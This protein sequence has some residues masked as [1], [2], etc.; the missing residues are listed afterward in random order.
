MDEDKIAK[1]KRMYPIGTQ[2]YSA[3]SGNYFTVKTNVFNN[4][5][6][7]DI[8]LLNGFGEEPF[9]F[10]RGRWAEII[11]LPESTTSEI[12]NQFPIY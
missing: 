9:V 5:A 8:K 2:F 7:G 6:G 11:S 1:A 3:Q 12:I 4:K 10:H